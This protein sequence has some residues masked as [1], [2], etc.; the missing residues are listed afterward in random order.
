[1]YIF[2]MYSFLNSLPT[3]CSLN[4][5]WNTVISLL[6]VWVTFYKSHFPWNS[7]KNTEG[8]W[9]LSPHLG[10]H[11]GLA[12]LCDPLI[13]CLHSISTST[14]YFSGS[15]HSPSLP[16]SMIQSY[17]F[18]PLHFSF[19]SVLSASPFSRHFSPSLCHQFCNMY[20]YLVFA[21]I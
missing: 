13:L 5:S 2:N 3:S 15:F 17:R 20:P 1:M 21:S 11:F 8:W 10:L 9:P 18:Y 16:V 6:S 19:F 12:Y 4:Y 7:G 14:S